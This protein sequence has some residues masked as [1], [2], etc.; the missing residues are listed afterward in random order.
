[1][2]LQV[3]HPHQQGGALEEPGETTQSFGAFGL[4]P[5]PAVSVVA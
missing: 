4:A 2:C 3:P 1:M 5:V